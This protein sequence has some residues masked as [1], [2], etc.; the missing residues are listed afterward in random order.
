MVIMSKMGVV[1][2]LATLTKGIAR[3]LQCRV[4]SSPKI[5]TVIKINNIT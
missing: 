3:M 1:V 2:A 4:I 5:I